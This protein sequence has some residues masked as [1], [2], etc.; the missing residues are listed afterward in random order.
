MATAV[1]PILRVGVGLTTSLRTN[2]M[3]E[4]TLISLEDRKRY[5]A[6]SMSITF[7]DWLIVRSIEKPST[8]SLMSS[9]I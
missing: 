7:T 6:P 8:F 3:N 9:M 5:T 4:K 2:L 1:L